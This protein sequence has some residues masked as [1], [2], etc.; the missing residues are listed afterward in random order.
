[1]IKTKESD[2]LFQKLGNTWYIFS[3]IENEIVYSALPHGM[4]PHSTKLEL[5]TVIED[6]L[7]R[8]AQGGKSTKNHNDAEA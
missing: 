4:D 6:H 5:Y 7:R 1:M 8:V 2:V 3:E